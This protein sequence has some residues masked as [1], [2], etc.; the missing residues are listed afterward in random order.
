LDGSIH[1]KIVKLLVLQLDRPEKKGLEE[2]VSN[3]IAVCK[4]LDWRA[5][6]HFWTSQDKVEYHN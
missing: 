1:A 3:V 2:V 5:S 4:Y 6:K